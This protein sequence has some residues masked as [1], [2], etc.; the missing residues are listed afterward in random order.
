MTEPLLSNQGIKL[1]AVDPHL[2]SKRCCLN[3][4][5]ALQQVTFC[6]QSA[7]IKENPSPLSQVVWPLLQQLCP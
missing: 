2:C 6:P 7:E 3:E 4:T 5:T 1:V